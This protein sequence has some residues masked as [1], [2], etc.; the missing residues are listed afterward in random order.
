RL[1]ADPLAA[2][3]LQQLVVPLGLVEEA[4]LAGGG[5]RQRD[6]L[7]GEVHRALG[8]GRVAERLQAGADDLLEVALADV[9]DVEHP[10]G[11]AEERMPLDA[12]AGGL[13][14][15]FLLPEAVAEV[16]AEQAELPEL[17]G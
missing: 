17:V 4:E 13:P 8:L 12:V 14:D 1:D 10:P 5:R 2:A 3:H 16:A 6:H 7:V 15:P 9:D 11:A